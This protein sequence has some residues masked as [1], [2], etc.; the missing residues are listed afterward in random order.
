MRV[1]KRAS[2][3]PTAVASVTQ[4]SL[5]LLVMVARSACLTLMRSPGRRPMATCWYCVTLA[6]A[7]TMRVRS[8]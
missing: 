1:T 3:P 7:R 8:R 5:A 6:G 2:L 4:A